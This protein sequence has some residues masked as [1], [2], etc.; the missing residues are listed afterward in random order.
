[1]TPPTPLRGLGF[2]FIGFGLFATHDALIKALGGTYSVFQIIFFAMLF[3][4]VPMATI[5]LADR[6]EANFRPKHPWLVMA[7]ATL[8]ILAMAS[9]FYAFATLPLTEVYALLFSA[10]LLITALSVP[11]LGE[12]VRAQRWAAVVV[13]LFGV[14]IVLRPGMTEV[15]LGHIAALTA[16]CAAALAS[17]VV[18]KIGSQE[19]SAV[20]I[21]YPMLLSMAVMG[22]LMPV[23]YKPVEL[24]D[25][26][27][28]ASVGL[29]SVIA[30][31]CI[32]SAYRAA[33]A[34]VIAPTQYS[35]I[36]WATLFGAVFFMEQPDAFVAV[37]SLVIITSGVFVVWRE[38]RQNVSV[39]N[40]VLKTANPRFDTGPSP[41][42]R[43]RP[44]T[45]ED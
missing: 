3:A 28:M 1:M 34:A 10:P 24:V 37:G 19:R 6:A 39:R 14:L 23:V 4:F 35:Q 45:A 33:P 21:L 41:G 15:T 22:G 38:S 36:I 43:Q 18:R 7:R 12:V 40:P 16:A 31:F 9:A 26:A 20:L 5:M 17:I 13:G 29:L 32:I 44:E 30:Q 27:M 25:L 42:L 11:F 2:A 8:S